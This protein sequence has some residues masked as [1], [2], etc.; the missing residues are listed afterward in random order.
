MISDGFV[1]F[2][3]NLGDTQKKANKIKVINL[4]KNL[5]I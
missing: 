1:V 4:K 5:V 2:M 3:T